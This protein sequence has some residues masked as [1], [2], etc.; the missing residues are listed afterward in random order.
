M[1][2]LLN[3]LPSF[4]PLSKQFDLL[5][6][7]FRV[8]LR[9][10]IG[11]IIATVHGINTTKKVNHNQQQRWINHQYNQQWTTSN[12]ELIINTTNNAQTQTT[13]NNV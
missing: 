4:T 12:I 11:C 8:S 6:Q 1:K 3:L 9:V 7:H 10:K 5:Y 2:V 13:N